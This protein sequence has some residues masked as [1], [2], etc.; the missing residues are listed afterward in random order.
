MRRREFICQAAG[1]VA[2]SLAWPG[3][4][5]GQAAAPQTKLSGTTNRKL[6]KTGI[7]CS[8]LGLGTGMRGWNGESDLTRKGRAAFMGMLEHVYGRGLTYFDLADMYG[9]HVYMRDAMKGPLD[10]DKVVIL[11]KTVSREAELVRADLERFRK[12]LDTDSIDIVLIHCLTEGD[13][14][15]WREKL[16]PCMDVLSEAKER[17]TIRAH[18]VSCHNLD[19]LR[20][21]AE[22]EWVDVILSRINPFGVKMDG[23]VEEVAGVLRKAHDNGKGVLGMKIVGEGTLTDKIQESL[24]FVVGLGCVDAMPIG[25]LEPGEVDQ[26]LDY[27]DALAATA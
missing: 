11:T 4:A 1:T 10:R 24:R 22:T 2:V 6:G 5:A 12:E 3:L 17:G 20:L 13:G 26:V 7:E 9:S 27:I 14:P 19:A 23:P 8:L 21:A 15:D 18:G 16:R 25:F